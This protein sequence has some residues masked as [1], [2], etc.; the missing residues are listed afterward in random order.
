MEILREYFA[1]IVLW[2]LTISLFLWFQ[3]YSLPKLERF[4]REEEEAKRRLA[5]AAPESH[6]KSSE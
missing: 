2:T 6:S 3:F 1:P 5:T 4:K